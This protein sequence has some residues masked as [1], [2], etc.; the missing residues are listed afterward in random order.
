MRKRKPRGQRKHTCAKC[1]TPIEESRKGKQSYCLS[2]H[3]K[4]MRDHRPKHSELPEQAR[5]KA[6]C[7]SYLNVYIRRGRIIRGP[8]EVCGSLNVH[9][10]H[11]DYSKPLQVRWLCKP[12]HQLLH[13]IGPLVD[14]PE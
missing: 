2:C 11:D 8:C 10:H 6:N 5:I 14:S 7:R 4:Y 13:G 9:A 3:R 12:H 1:N